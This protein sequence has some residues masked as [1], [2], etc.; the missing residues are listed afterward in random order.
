MNVSELA[1]KLNCNIV[2]GAGGSQSEI[3]GC[4]IGDLLSLAMSR[5]QKG[6]VW[7]TIQSNIN[8][9]AVATL[10]EAA[11]IIVCD[12]FAPDENTVQ[13]AEDENIPILSSDKPAYELA[14]LLSGY[15][16]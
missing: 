12:G 3:S 9:A 4:Y 5:V 1:N 11:C 8:I 14:K 2:C 13:R 7:I 10:T 16:I 6:N 15:G